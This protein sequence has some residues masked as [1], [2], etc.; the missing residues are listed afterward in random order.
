MRE[1]QRQCRQCGTCCKK[2][3]PALHHQDTDLLR[4]G[5][6]SY[7]QLVTIREGELAYS[8][9]SGELEPVDREL[10]KVNGQGGGWTCL[11][12]NS[13]NSSCGIYVQ[14]PLECRLLKCWEPD[15]VLAVAGKETI[16]RRD[17]VNAGDPVIDLIAH[18]QRE[19]PAEAVAQAVEGW[20]QQPANEKGRNV[21]AD[22]VRRD[23]ALRN[24]AVVDLGLPPEVEFFVFGRPLFKQLAG[25]GFAI[26]EVDGHLQFLWPE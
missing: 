22:L 4:E 19:C 21:L 3:G 1:R 18:Q 15:E 26:R 6:I 9:G 14:R 2:G 12:Y 20:R 11:F 17:I 10:V 25:F 8:P 13:E 24:H 16:C 5:T 7:S 23:L